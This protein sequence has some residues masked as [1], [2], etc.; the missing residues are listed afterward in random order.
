[1]AHSAD[2]A[3]PGWTR[4]LGFA[5]VIGGLVLVAAFLP[6]LQLSPELATLRVVLFNVGAIAVV[7]AVHRRNAR[8]SR[9]LSLAAAVPA[10]L[11]N[12][13][14]L[15]MVAVSL[16]RPQPP[17]GD[18]DF[19]LVMFAAGAA[20]WLA[21]AAFGLVTLRLRAASRLGALALVAGSLLAVGGMD[22]LG[23]VSGDVAWLFGPVA[24]LGVALNGAG[25][26]LLGL[27]VAIRRG[28][29]ADNTNRPISLATTK[30]PAAAAAP[31]PVG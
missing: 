10:I 13:W 16:G 14:Y 3:P 28:P 18:P 5:G 17:V 12:A 21:D 23:L 11:A 29:P 7:L 15:A 1:V 31:D 8:V 26:I 9:R 20:M 22:R 19:R 25:W 30:G 27:D 6:N 24:L 4:A 2:V